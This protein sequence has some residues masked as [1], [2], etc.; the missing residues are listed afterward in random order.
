MI[1]DLPWVKIP[2]PVPEKPEKGALEKIELQK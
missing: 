1:Y 2:I